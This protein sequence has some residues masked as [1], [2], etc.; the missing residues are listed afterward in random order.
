MTGIATLA[1]DYECGT[2]SAYT[3]GCRCPECREA[4]RERERQRVRRVRAA[5]AD[6]TPSGPPIASTMRRGG[7]DV[8]ILRCPGVNGATCV[9]PGAAWLKGQDVCTACVCRATV[10]DGLVP[11]DRAREH[12]RALS[13]VGYKAVGDAC[14]VGYT[15]LTR[16]ISGSP[17][18]IRARIERAILG[19]DTGAMADG[20]AVDAT[21]TN[22]QIAALRARGFTLR[23]LARLLGYAANASCCQIGTKPR[24]SVATRAKVAR[25]VAR[26]ERGEVV[27]QRAAVEAPEERAFLTM[28]LDRGVN[29][30]WLTERLGFHVQRSTRRMMVENAAAVRALRDEF[31][32]LRREGTERPDGW[33]SAPSA[34]TAAFGFGGGW[35]WGG[36]SPGGRRRKAPKPKPPPKVRAPAMA[37]EERRRRCRE[38]ARVRRAALG[39]EAVREQNNRDARRMRARRA[40]AQQ[41]AA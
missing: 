40:A 10:W 13:A 34:I 33:E 28:L 29:H 20:A 30:R 7:R 11:P 39:V 5:R 21:E 41:A 16:I 2:R 8:R 18:P 15:T 12:M 31:E 25:L 26:V 27:P 24:T 6:V 17:T 38:A 35:S 32:S 36:T 37:D 14:D 4:N 22:A 3:R 23:H 19:V 1:R 9:V